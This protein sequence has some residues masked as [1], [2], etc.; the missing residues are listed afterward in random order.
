MNVEGRPAGRQDQIMVRVRRTLSL[1][2][3]FAP[4]QGAQYVGAWLFPLDWPCDSTRPASRRRLRLPLHWLPAGRGWTFVW[5]FLLP[6]GSRL[7][8]NASSEYPRPTHARTTAR[9]IVS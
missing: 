1:P 7:A 3:S 9:S 8:I 6:A 5:A 4:D 2:T